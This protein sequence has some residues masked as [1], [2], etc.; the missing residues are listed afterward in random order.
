MLA[1][2]L[3]VQQL[4]YFIDRRR[5]TRDGAQADEGGEVAHA[6]VEFGDENGG[7]RREG[8]RVDPDARRLPFGGA[9]AGAVDEGGDLLGEGAAVVELGHPVDGRRQGLAGQL[10]QL[11]QLGLGEG[12]GEVEEEHTVIATCS[13]SYTTAAKNS[14]GTLIAELSCSGLSLAP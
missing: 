12:V 2:G 14:G 3:Q 13:L 8:G 9:E 6:A 7:D 4:G 5:A 11:G 10:G 1:N